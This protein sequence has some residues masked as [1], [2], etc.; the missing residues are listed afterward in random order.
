MSED[1]QVS[2]VVESEHRSPSFSI[3]G[4]A[5]EMVHRVGADWRHVGALEET[6]MMAIDGLPLARKDRPDARFELF[7]A[8]QSPI[9]ELFLAT[10]SRSLLWSWQPQNEPIDDSIY[11]YTDILSEPLDLHRP[12]GR[13]GHANLEECPT[14]VSFDDPVLVYQQHKIL[15]FRADFAFIGKS[16]KL[17]VELDGHNFHERTKEQAQRDKARDRQ[18]QS[19]GWTIFRFTGSEL[20]KSPY[21]SVL[22]VLRFFERV[23]Q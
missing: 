5:R 22:E 16:Q 19:E 17:V 11:A 9:E 21:N 20:W 3:G 8:C 6:L 10:L 23:S 4:L 12:I 2:E 15:N 18:M 7:S 13:L 14:S 1:K